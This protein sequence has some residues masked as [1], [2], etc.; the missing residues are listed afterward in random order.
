MSPRERVL[1]SIGHGDP[2]RVPVDLGATRSSGISAIAYSRLRKHLGLSGPVRVYD[3][4]QQLALVDDDILDRFGIDA[5]DMARAFVRECSWRDWRLWDGTACLV[6]TYFEPEL[7]ENGDWLVKDADGDVVA[8]MAAG[9]FYFTQTIHPLA[10]AKPSEYATRLPQVMKKV[11]WGAIPTVSGHL[12]MGEEALARIGE[13]AKW[14]YENT[15]RAIVATFGGNLLEAAQNLRGFDVFLMDLV[16][17]PAGVEKLLD[18]LL[19]VH[20]GNLAKFLK[21]VGPYIQVIKFGDDLGTGNGP[22]FDP[23]MYR[24][25]FKGR[26][27]KMYQYVRA[28]G[29]PHVLL[30]SCGGI[31]P[32]IGDLIDAGV[33]ILNPVQTSSAGMGAGELKREFGKD[34][35]FWGGGCDTAAILPRGTTQEVKQC[36]R[37]RMEIFSPGGG[38]VFSSIHNVTP[39]VPPENVLAMFEA[40]SEFH[41]AQA[42]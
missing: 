42:M 22:Q 38:F 8:R 6:P 5:V 1:T 39:E 37:E 16:M 21:A 25:F 14:L 29:G 30:H 40:V 12:G 7:Q 20:M 34:I 31:R 3:L 4:V 26:H 24:K 35:T 10:E 32:I 18:R 17:D 41:Q 9:S 2:D 33:E 23:A 28:Y 11:S 19:E 15:D 36:V 13:R 27:A